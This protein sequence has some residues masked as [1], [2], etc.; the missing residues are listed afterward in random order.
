M[1][2]SISKQGDDMLRHYHYEAAGCL[3][4]AVTAP[5]ALRSRELKFAK[6]LGPKRARSAVVRKLAVLLLGFGRARIISKPCRAAK[7][8]TTVFLK[9]IRG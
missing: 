6:C 1:T 5:C 3:L 2:G 7:P 9:F 4:T 8:F